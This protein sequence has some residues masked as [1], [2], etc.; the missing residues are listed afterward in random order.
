MPERFFIS[1]THFGH[2]NI[3]KFEPELRPFKTIEEHD[4]FIIVE[5]NAR[6]GKN[7]VVYHLGDVAF[8][9]FDITLLNELNGHKR[10]ILGNHDQY[11]RLQPYFE[12]F[13]GAKFWKEGILLTHIPSHINQ[14]ERFKYNF[15]GHLHSK[16]LDDN[17]Y[18]N[19]SCE[20]TCCRPISYDEIKERLV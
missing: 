16:K 4:Q 14:L 17:R 3:L 12:D 5:W 11:S 9:G 7:D 20:W 6:V 18:V 1:D 19:L 13:S 8:R 10:L 15:H 2:A